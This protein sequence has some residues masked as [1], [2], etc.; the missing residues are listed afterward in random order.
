MMLTVIVAS[1]GAFALKFAGYLLGEKFAQNPRFR[2]V[3]DLMPVGLL[4]GLIIVQAL[5][6]Q[7]QLVLDGRL[8]GVAVAVILLLRRA[9][10]IAV[11][12]SAALITAVGRAFGWWV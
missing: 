5:S 9:P 3:S 8:V 6:S 11:I 2:R 7:Q 1:L 10:F 12:L 4:A